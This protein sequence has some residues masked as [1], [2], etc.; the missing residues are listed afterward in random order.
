[1][2]NMKRSSWASGNGYV[3]SCSIGFCVAITKNGSGRLYVSCPT[4][5]WRSCIACKRAAWVFGGV[6]LISSASTIWAKIGP[7]TKRNSRLPELSSRMVVPVM[8]DGI[9]SGVNW[10]RLNWT[11]RICAIEL[12][13]SVLARPGTPTR[14]Q[15]PRVKTAARICSMTSDWPTTVRRNWSRMESRA[16]LNCSRYS[17]ILSVDTRAFR[18]VA[19]AASAGGP[20]QADAGSVG[21]EFIVT[22]CQVKSRLDDKRVLGRNPADFAG[23]QADL[24][25]VAA[26]MQL[27]R[28]E[29]ARQH[30]EIGML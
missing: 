19:D 29:A 13:I 20:D 12:T 1:M 17:L 9:R 5:T 23:G 18:F 7:L 6:R 25:P 2:L 15:C 16:L 4:V 8:S 22:T 3:P 24:H 21:Y 14:R 30:R 11:S 27:P 28:F 10:M 26:A